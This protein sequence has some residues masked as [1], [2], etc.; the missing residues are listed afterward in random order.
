MSRLISGGH[1]GSRADEGSQ[2]AADEERAGH[3][4]Q[5][6]KEKGLTIIATKLYVNEKGIAKLVIALAKGK[7]SMTSGS[8]S[9]RRTFVARWREGNEPES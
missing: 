5:A 6:V 4:R 2:A 7:R 1:G 8:P 9:R 3:L